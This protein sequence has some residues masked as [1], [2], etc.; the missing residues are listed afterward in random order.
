[1]DGIA[2][3]DLDREVRLAGR[4][5]VR[6]P[7]RDALVQRTFETWTHRDDIGATRT[8]A[9]PEQVHRII[10]LAVT[11]LPDARQ[12]EVVLLAYY[13]GRTYRQVAR[14]LGIPEGT[15]KSRIKAA[16][17]DIADRLAAEGIIER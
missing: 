6:R 2:G 15:A 4:A 10:D 11:L 17:A 3:V 14:D 8:V 13:R 7:V 9:P 16:L 12:R 1:M 5:G